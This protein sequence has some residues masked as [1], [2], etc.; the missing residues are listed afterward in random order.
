MFFFFIKLRK[1]KE[2]RKFVAKFRN[3]TYKMRMDPMDIPNIFKIDLLLETL[4]PISRERSLDGVFEAG[5]MYFLKRPQVCATGI[6]LAEDET[7]FLK[8]IWS[9]TRSNSDLKNWK[10][11]NETLEV[12]SLKDR[13]IGAAARDK[14]IIIACGREWRRPEWAKKENINSYIVLPMLFKGNLI[15]VLGNFYFP[16][17][18]DGLDNAARWLNLLSDYIASAIANAKAFETIEWLSKRLEQR[19]QYL[20][21]E[22]RH[23]TSYDRILGQSDAV[24]HILSQI[25]IVSPTEA[26]VLI[27][28]E[29]GTGKDL[30]ASAIHDRSKRANKPFIK[31]NCA[32]VPRDLFESEFFGHVQGAFTGA[33]KD[34]VGRFQLADGGT[35]L[36]DEV[37]EMPLELQ[38]KLLRVI[39]EGEFE[40]VGEGVTQK[41]SVRIIAITNRNIKQEVKAGRFREDL[42]FRLS[43]FPIDTPPLRDRKEDIELLVR[44]FK[45]KAEIQ[46]GLPEQ[47]LKENT[48]EGLLRLNWPGNIRELQN[49]VERAV[50][51]SR[52]GEIDFGFLSYNDLDSQDDL[53][54][55]ICISQ[56]VITENNWKQLQRINIIKA[57]KAA[58]WK[59][60][61]EQSASELLEIKP[62]TLR[63]RMLSLG[64]HNKMLKY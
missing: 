24:Q 55:N 61:G 38:G 56:K 54:Q 63:S 43:V 26:N 34:R 8:L 5:K 45:R 6:W 51:T 13:I 9:Q 42:F 11:H 30:I 20:R 17:F 3:I 58:N 52:G 39:Q 41:V 31:A 50:I 44:H 46:L 36:L 29:S 15:G 35:L 57:L 49:A 10:H 14:R 64:I 18:E 22:V 40:R 12:I 4:L 7:H 27:L 37:C 60:Q 19:K 23:K 16:L 62:T 25:D 47:N 28:G 48:L 1:F 59:I 21:E 33:V 2:L 53:E 32:S